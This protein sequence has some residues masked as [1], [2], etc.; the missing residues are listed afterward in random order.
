M[1]LTSEI[2]GVP[3]TIIKLKLLS[4]VVRAESIMA[5]KRGAI[6]VQNRAKENISGE[7]G[8]TRHIKTGNLRRNIKS[9]VGWAS[10]FELVGIIGTDV[11]YAPYIEAL[12]DGGFLY[13]ALVEVGDQVVSMVRDDIGKVIKGGFR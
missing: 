10:T 9:K 2:T 8:H 11:D 6:M 13:P 7:N 1:N 12:P 5:M 3:K 4:E